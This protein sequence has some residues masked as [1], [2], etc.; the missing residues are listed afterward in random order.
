MSE[1][2]PRSKKRQP[3]GL[4]ILHE[5]R[6]IIV[7]NKEAGLL[8]VGTGRDAARTAH[9]SLTNYVRKGNPKS[10]ERVFI[11]HRL[12]RDTSGVLVFARTME[13][14][15][16]LQT[17]W[18]QSNKFY[19][20]FVEGHPE[21][22]KGTISSHLVENSALRVYSTKD[23]KAGKLAHTRYE[24]IRKTK[25]RALLKI[26]LLTGRKNQ[27][28]VHLADKG[29]PIVGDS[30]YG[31][32]GPERLALHSLSLTL[33]HPH[34]GE[35]LTFE[36]APPASFQYMGLAPRKDPAKETEKKLADPIKRAQPGKAIDPAVRQQKRLRRQQPWK[37]Q[38][39]AKPAD[40]AMPAPRSKRKRPPQGG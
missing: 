26:E 15:I 39:A 2:R 18:E 16:K 32:K 6:D 20:A 14:K 9:A 38:Q 8:T 13:A 34:T 11:V 36:A 17:T 4:E 31:P 23:P 30:K 3:S 10:F 37:D 5:D 25:D 7:V 24:V 35:L 1:P 12:D 21:P 22:E 29:W 19:L 40:P 28:R 27:I 33:N